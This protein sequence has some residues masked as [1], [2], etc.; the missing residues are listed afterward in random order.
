MLLF[1]KSKPCFM[2]RGILIP[3]VVI[4]ARS[5]IGVASA[6]PFLGASSPIKELSK[7]ITQISGVIPIPEEVLP[8]VVADNVLGSGIY[9]SMLLKHERENLV[10]AI[11]TSSGTYKSSSSVGLFT[12]DKSSIIGQQFRLSLCDSQRFN[13]HNYRES[14]ATKIR[15]KYIGE[16]FNNDSQNYKESKI[17]VSFNDERS[18]C[19]QLC[20]QPNGDVIISYNGQSFIFDIKSPT[21]DNISHG[22]GLMTCLIGRSVDYSLFLKTYS[23]SFDY[24]ARSG[25]FTQEYKHKVLD[26]EIFS[27]ALMLSGHSEERKIFEMSFEV[28]KF[29]MENSNPN[30]FNIPVLVVDPANTVFGQS[31]LRELLKTPELSSIDSQANNLVEDV[32]SN[33]NDPSKLI[34]IFNY[35]LSLFSGGVK[36]NTLAHIALDIANNSN[37]KPKNIVI[38]PHGVD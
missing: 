34:S 4:A 5:S 7:D 36:V 35:H 16:N 22:S 2:E 10:A 38:D 3:E 18:D 15:E 29:N 8:L 24:I 25:E 20:N 1:G 19:V 23:E 13:K 21:S 33:T 6:N 31:T 11:N 17:V 14:M 27:E 26:L 32:V 9:N 30:G 37:K 28:I 12:V